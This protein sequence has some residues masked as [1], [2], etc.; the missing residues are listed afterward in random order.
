MKL[1]LQVTRGF[2][3]G[4]V[5]KESACNA[6]NLGSVPESGSSPGG[7]NDNPLQYCWLRNSMDRGAQWATVHKVARAG[8]D[9]VAKVPPGPQFNTQPSGWSMPFVAAALWVWLLNYAEGLW[10]FYFFVVRLKHVYCR[11]FKLKALASPQKRGRQPII[12]INPIVIYCYYFLR[13]FWFISMRLCHFIQ[14]VQ[15]HTL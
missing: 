7:R 3:G 14:R 11:N 6:G 2:P 13:S 10:R 5:C 1:K 4:S 9:S 8:R 12:R 15:C